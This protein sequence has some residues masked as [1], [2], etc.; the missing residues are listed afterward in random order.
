MFEDDL[1]QRTTI[2]ELPP[3]LSSPEAIAF[4]QD[5]LRNL[6]FTG[7]P[8]T[9]KRYLGMLVEDIILDGKKVRIRVKNEGILA[10]LEQ[11]EKLSTGEVAPVLNSVYKWRPQRDSNSCR[12][13]ERAVS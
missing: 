8:Q 5:E 7:S 11:K 6:V 4:I 10:L 2:K 1:E 3:Y 13:R 9:V 12:R